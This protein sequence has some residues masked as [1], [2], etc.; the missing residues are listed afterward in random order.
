MRSFDIFLKASSE[1]E[2]TLPEKLHL[3]LITILFRGLGACF[4]V[5]LLSVLSPAIAV[6][7]VDAAVCRCPVH[8]H[9][10]L[11]STVLH[12]RLPFSTVLIC[13]IYPLMSSTA[14]SRPLLSPPLLFSLGFHF[15]P[16]SPPLLPSSVV[17][18]YRGPPSRI[19]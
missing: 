1:L 5:W 12:C 14:L 3:H 11:S 7:A 16:N 19:A 17:R 15:L 18:T 4:K 13:P 6:R 2:P 9:P 8:P 10:L